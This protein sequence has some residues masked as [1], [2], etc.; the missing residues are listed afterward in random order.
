M[1]RSAEELV[2]GLVEAGLRLTR[3]RRVVCEIVA[4]H[5]DEHLTAQAI[6][7]LATERGV[8]VD[9]ATVYRTLEAL[10]RV[11]LVRHAHLGHGPSVYHLAD[12]RPHQPL[13]CTGCGATAAIPAEDLADFVVVLERATGY[14]PDV[15]HFAMAARCPACREPS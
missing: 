15:E 11:G 2:G 5:H 13:V 10:E 1:H 8:S 12:E 3:P 9:R 7:T 6:L 14:S 4:D